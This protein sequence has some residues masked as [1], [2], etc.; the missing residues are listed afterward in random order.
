MFCHEL[1]QFLML[2]WRW[3]AGFVFTSMYDTG[4]ERQYKCPIAVQTFNTVAMLH[5]MWNLKYNTLTIHGV[6]QHTKHATVIRGNRV[7]LRYTFF[8]RPVSR[9]CFF[10]VCAIIILQ[11]IMTIMGRKKDTIILHHIDTSL[12]MAGIRL[13]HITNEDEGD[14]LTAL[15]YIMSMTVD[16]VGM[17]VHK[18]DT[19]LMFSR[20]DLLPPAI[21]KYLLTFTYTNRQIPYWKKN[22]WMRSYGY[23]MEKQTHIS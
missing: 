20:D 15:Q 5:C 7:A 6:Q 10:T 1:V 13:W 18:A 14:S 4:F 9:M 21:F 23:Y 2:R 16:M 12:A 3:T 22:C 17:T 8:P 19:S 11:Y